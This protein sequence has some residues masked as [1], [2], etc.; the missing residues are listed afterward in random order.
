[1]RKAAN[2]FWFLCE[3]CRYGSDCSLISS[4]SVRQPLEKD[5]ELALQHDASEGCGVYKS[6]QQSVLGFESDGMEGTHLLS[7]CSIQR[8]GLPLWEHQ[9]MIG[10]SVFLPD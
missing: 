8:C 2:M 9:E 5:L 1:M 7:S 3:V 6:V 4:D 10:C